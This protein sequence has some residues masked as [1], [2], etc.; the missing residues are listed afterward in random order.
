MRGESV[1]VSALIKY[2]TSARFY[3]LDAGSLGRCCV[4]CLSVIM[5]PPSSWKIRNSVWTPSLKKLGQELFTN[6]TMA[7]LAG[8][9]MSCLPK[10]AIWEEIDSFAKAGKAKSTLLTNYMNRIHSLVGHLKHDRV[11]R[12]NF[13]LNQIW[14]FWP[15]VC[16]S[17]L[18]F[19]SYSRCLKRRLLFKIPARR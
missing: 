2:A 5:P 10:G 9:F 1:I 17:S 16:R 8:Y 18:V 12:F 15:K 7:R 6:G 19:P 11:V 4:D 14:H 13:N 3:E